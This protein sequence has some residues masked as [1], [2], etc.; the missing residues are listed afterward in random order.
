[1]DR[2]TSILSVIPYVLFVWMWVLL[3]RDTYVPDENL[4]EWANAMHVRLRRWETNN[5]LRK[6]VWA[7]NKELLNAER[8]FADRAYAL[9]QWTFDLKC[10][11]PS[12]PIVTFV[13]LS[14]QRGGACWLR[15]DEPEAKRYAEA[16]LGDRKWN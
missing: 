3:L 11:P 16:K 13:D 10:I 12:M 15:A 14:R 9:D 2:L 5:S 4:R 8:A 6:R 1:M 7:V